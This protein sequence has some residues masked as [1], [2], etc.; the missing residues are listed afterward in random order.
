MQPWRRGLLPAK[1]SSRI[2]LPCRDIVE[3]CNSRGCP[4]I[5]EGFK[6]VAHYVFLGGRGLEKGYRVSYLPFGR[7]FRCGGPYSFPGPSALCR[8]CAQAG[9]GGG[10]QQYGLEAMTTAKPRPTLA[11][12]ETRSAPVLRLT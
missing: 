10:G 11:P 5:F 9:R 6:H 1:P 3:R 7:R 12:C 8:G 2:P 4:P